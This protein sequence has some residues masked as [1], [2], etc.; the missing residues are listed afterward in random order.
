MDFNLDERRQGLT[1]D[2]YSAIRVSDHASKKNR[3]SRLVTNPWRIG[4][5]KLLSLIIASCIFT[6]TRLYYDT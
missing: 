6:K 5:P 2:L 4:Y 1:N 3:V